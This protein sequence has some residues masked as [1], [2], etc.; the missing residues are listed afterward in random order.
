MDAQPVR[1]SFLIPTAGRLD[2]LRRTLRALAELEA[3]AGSFEAVVVIDGGMAEPAAGLAGDAGRM[4]MRVV[5]QRRSGPARARNVAAARARGEWLIFLDDDCRPSADFLT[6][7]ETLLAPDPRLAIGGQPLEPG[8][9]GLWSVATHLVVEAFVESGRGAS[10]APGF[11]PSQNLVVHRTAWARTGGFNEAFRYAGGEDRE[12]CLRW[13][14]DGGRFVRVTELAYV[15]DA[16]LPFW[17]YV[18][19]HFRY[20]QGAMRCRHATGRRPQRRYRAFA[21]ALARRAWTQQ[22][23]WRIP[24]LAVA[25][26]LSQCATLAGMVSWGQRDEAD[27]VANPS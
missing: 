20:G 23:R 25:L 24:A 19:K 10:G 16:P 3:P 18:R 7:L 22:P 14:A 26:A 12:F 5:T 27:A 11:L 15:H 13:I 2:R 21:R 17:S 9:G 8:S 1:F 6:T 4:P